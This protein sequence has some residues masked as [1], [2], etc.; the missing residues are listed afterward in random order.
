MIFAFGFT[1]FVGICAVALIGLEDSHYRV[2]RLL[3]ELDEQSAER[4]AEARIHEVGPMV[5]AH[6]TE[7]AFGELA[8]TRSLLALGKVETPVPC[9][10]PTHVHAESSSSGSTHPDQSKN[11][12]Q[13]L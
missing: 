12:V 6:Q 8:F 11:R 1:V 4:P 2:T 5:T 3:E 7:D 9:D 10:S 13:V